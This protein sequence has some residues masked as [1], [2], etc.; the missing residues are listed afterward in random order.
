MGYD[1]FG[2]PAEQYA[3]QTCQHPGVTTAENIK[4]YRDQLD[5]MGF[6]FDWSREVQTCD[7]KYYKWTQWIFLKLFG[8]WYN[9]GAGKAEPIESLIGIFETKGNQ[10]VL[11]AS[12]ETRKFD[13][14][15][16]KGFSE[17]EKQTILLNYR[18]AFLSNTMVNWCP[19]LGT[20]LE[21]EEVK[22]RQL[23][24]EVI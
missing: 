5:R 16:W 3:I 19:A 12:G 2:L 10:S 24:K 9:Q 7:P 6:S 4:R 1:A 8:S 13:A 21:N 23:T 17:I 11:A 22:E 14:D 20:V 18:L 15:T